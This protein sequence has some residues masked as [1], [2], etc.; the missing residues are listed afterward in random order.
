M[1]S[2]NKLAT[3]FESEDENDFVADEKIQNFVKSSIEQEFYIGT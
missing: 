3:T 1:H 2:N